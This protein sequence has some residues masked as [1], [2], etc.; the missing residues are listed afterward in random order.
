M[1]HA[2]II[3]IVLASLFV[4][5]LVFVASTFLNLYIQA[6]VSEAYVSMPR[7]VRMRLR[8]LDPHMI[9]YSRIRSVKA[10]VPIDV[11]RIENHALAGGDV[12]TVVS[13]LIAAD[14]AGI[15][16]GWEAATS[17]DLA[18]HDPLADIE[19]QIKEQ[20]DR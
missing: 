10:G 4:L 18:G 11:D 8:G 16:L 19:A 5:L 17:I 12:A 1:Q 6:L 7:L 13:A 3:A 20:G 9:V 2:A 14:R 15:R